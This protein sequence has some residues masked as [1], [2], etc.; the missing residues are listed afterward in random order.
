MP[1]YDDEIIEDVNDQCKKLSEELITKYPLL[2]NRF[3]IYEVMKHRGYEIDIQN[4]I[5][6]QIKSAGIFIADVSEHIC[7]KGTKTVDCHANPNVMYELGLAKGQPYT[8]I[9]LLKNKNDK[10][11]VPSDIITKYYNKFEFD[12]KVS[13]RKK[14]FEA[15][16]NILKDKFEII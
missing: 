12:K 4:Q 7:K 3:E 16:E 13:M 1:Y 10:I 8:E 11:E 14:L 2:E 6:E 15:I 5:M 9:I